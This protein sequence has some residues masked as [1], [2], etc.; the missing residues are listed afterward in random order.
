VAPNYTAQPFDITASH[1]QS[2]T[3]Y[4]FQ[5]SFYNAGNGQII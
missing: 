1:L 3:T 4:Y 5:I 2:N